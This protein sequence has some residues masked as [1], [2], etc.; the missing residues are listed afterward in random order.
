MITKEGFTQLNITHVCVQTH[1]TLIE[2]I[3]FCSLKV[4]Q[5]NL[6]LFEFQITKKKLFFPRKQSAVEL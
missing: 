3:E 2:I 4:N 1:A 6:Y 5:K